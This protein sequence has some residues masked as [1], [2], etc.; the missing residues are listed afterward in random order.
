M[1]TRTTNYG[2][3]KPDPTDDYVDFLSEFNANM[4]EI[5]EHLGSGGSGGG[6]SI[7]YSTTERVIGTWID[8]KPLYQITIEVNNPVND[9]NE[10]LID[11]TSLSIAECPYLFG[12]AVRQAGANQITY[13]SNSIET[14]GWYYFKARYDNFRSSIMY[15]CLFQNDSIDRMKFTIQ[16]TKVTD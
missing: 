1:A 15:I 12:Y 14:D 2:L 5:D 7:Q 13:Y 10:H 6:G 3:Y 8:N 16:Y 9:S 4:D 11:L